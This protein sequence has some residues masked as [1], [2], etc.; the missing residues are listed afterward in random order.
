M[1]REQVVA[2]R[3]KDRVHRVRIEEFHPLR[4]N[5]QEHLVGTLEP[6]TVD[7]FHVERYREQDTVENPLHSHQD[8]LLSLGR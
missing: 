3:L 5:P 4:G 6:I 8:M 2:I 7:E 1:D